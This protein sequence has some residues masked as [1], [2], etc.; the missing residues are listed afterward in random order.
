MGLSSSWTQSRPPAPT[1]TEA[2]LPSQQGKV[3][4]VTGGNNGVGYQL[5]KMLYGNAI[6]DRSLN[7]SSPSCSKW[8]SRLHSLAVPGARLQGH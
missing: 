8:S 3:F 6:L 2:N 4:I 1:L 7:L 5:S